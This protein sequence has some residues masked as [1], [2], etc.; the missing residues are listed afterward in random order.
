MIT[1]IKYNK[2]MVWE[3][4]KYDEPQRILNHIVPL[5]YTIQYKS[6][7]NLITRHALVRKKILSLVKG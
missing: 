4:R 1:C 6:Q 3:K 2:I 5:Y 7:N